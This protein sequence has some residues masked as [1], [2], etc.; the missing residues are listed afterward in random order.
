MHPIAAFLSS[1]FESFYW[2]PTRRE[3]LTMGSKQVFNADRDR[4]Y[5]LIPL[6]LVCVTAAFSAGHIFFG[7]PQAASWIMYLDYISAACCAI[8]LIYIAALP[9]NRNMLYLDVWKDANSAYVTTMISPRAVFYE[10]SSNDPADQLEKF[11]RVKIYSGG[12][13]ALLFT[14]AWVYGL[15]RLISHPFGIVT[16]LILETAHVALIIALFSIGQTKEHNSRNSLR[17]FFNA[18]EASSS[19]TADI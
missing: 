10:I 8:G 16:T 3:W 9:W 5:H 19:M 7:E 2:L 18:I 11:D 6:G 1:M 17:G 13:A 12:A 4:L 14:P 15:F